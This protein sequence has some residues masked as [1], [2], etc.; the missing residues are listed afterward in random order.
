MLPTDFGSNLFSDIACERRLTDYCLIGV[1]HMSC[2]TDDFSVRGFLAKKTDRVP[3]DV[4]ANGVFS[5]S[6][7]T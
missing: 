3:Y 2:V 6:S 4:P 5:L 7:L 1:P